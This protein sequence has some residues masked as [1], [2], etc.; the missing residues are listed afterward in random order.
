MTKRLIALTAWLMFMLPAQATDDFHSFVAQINA[1]N[2]SRS[3]TITLSGDIALA[4]A[5]PAISGTITIDGNGHSISGS[6][7]FRIFDIDGGSLTIK[8]A[9]LTGGRANAGGALRLRNGASVTLE[10]A[11]LQGNRATNGGAIAL[12][13]S[14]DQLVVRESRFERNAAE[15]SAGAIYANGGRVEIANSAFVRN[16]G[17]SAINQLTSDKPIPN[18]RRDIDADGCVFVG[19]FWVERILPGDGGAIRLLNGARVTIADSSFSHNKASHGGA[20]AASSASDRLTISGSSF[21]ENRAEVASGAIRIRGGSLAITGSSFVEN[22][23]LS[24]AGVLAMHGG[25][26]DIS[27]STFHNNHALS[28]GGVMTIE[29]AKATLTHLTMIGN[30]TTHSGGAAIYRSEGSSGLA[31]T[32]IALRNSIVAGGAHE[33]CHGGLDESFGNLSVDGS[34]GLA[35]GGEFLLGELTGDPATIPLLDHSPAVDA[36][37]PAYC[38]ET[39]QLGTARP[40]GGGCDIG[41]FESTTAEPAPVPIVP[42]PPCP[43]ALQ[44]VAANTDKPAGGCRAGSGHDIIKLDRDITLAE[45]LPH[46]TSE[47]TI[48]GNGHSISG[49]KKYRIFSVDSGTLTINN[50][51]LSDGNARGINER[52]GALR[53]SGRGAAIVNDSVFINNRAGSGGAIAAEQEPAKLAV[54]SSHFQ[55]NRASADGGAI[56]VSVRSRA[57]IK[58]SSF[59]NNTGTHTGGAIS[60]FGGY[61]EVSNSAFT[62]NLAYEGG[63]IYSRWAFVTL[64]HLTMWDNSG[65]WSGVLVVEPDGIG[66]VKLRNSII[67]GGSR[68]DCRGTLAENRGNFI[69]DGSCSPKLSGDPMLGEATG[70]PLY[71][72]LQP[73]SPAID[74]AHQAY[75]T[76]S[77]QLG[78]PRPRFSL[79]DIGAIE[80]TP[81]SRDIAECRVK[82]THTLN[83]RETPG[84]ERIGSVPEGATMPASARTPGWFQVEYRGRSGWISADYVTSEGACD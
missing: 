74:A 37:D 77:D 75:C 48:E 81:V 31:G 53:V 24:S 15:R 33:D 9:M 7:Q 47:I 13:S 72:P 84:G 2:S 36:A 54:N 10:S 58:G 18:V 80:S 79:C 83:F 68:H 45:P 39:D 51:T 20:I 78:N 14:A 3:A 25:S 22:R 26:L 32:F 59:V 66:W 21:S 12:S 70:M 73:G 11:T 55:G 64:T 82:T 76:R 61:L 46:I 44:I 69:A 5:L 50:L 40:Q 16:C 19:E 65:G 17:E 23:A 67:A 60:T 52:G 56:S 30:S 41:A 27:N 62:D 34:C 63:A 42:P 8:N 29:G 43:L 28:V 6:E 4:Y 38:L 1:A 57:K 71:M 49:D 35:S